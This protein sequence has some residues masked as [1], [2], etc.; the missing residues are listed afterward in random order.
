MPCMSRCNLACF[1]S[2]E[3]GQWRQFGLVGSG[4]GLQLGCFSSSRLIQCC[5]PNSTKHRTDQYCLAKYGSEPSRWWYVCLHGSFRLSKV[6][7]QR[8]LWAKWEHSTSG[9]EWPRDAALC[10]EQD[11]AE[12]SNFALRESYCRETDEF[13]TFC[14]LFHT[15]NRKWNR[16]CS[17]QMTTSRKF[18]A[19]SKVSTEDH[20]S[21]TWRDLWCW[22]RHGQSIFKRYLKRTRAPADIKLTSLCLRW[23]RRKSRLYKVPNQP[24]HRS[25]ATDINP[26]EPR[27]FSGEEQGSHHKNSILKKKAAE[28]FVGKKMLSP[29]ISPNQVSWEIFGV[30]FCTQHDC[31]ITSEHQHQPQ[32]KE[33]T[34]M[35]DTKTI[36][37]LVFDPRGQSRYRD[38]GNWTMC[39]A[40]KKTKRMVVIQNYILCKV[41]KC[42]PT[43][44][45]K[46]AR[47]EGQLHIN[48]TACCPDID[49]ELKI[50]LTQLWLRT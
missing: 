28:R 21:T 48:C 36:L 3:G 12:L 34:E 32:K 46:Q 25:G 40:M 20:G 8:F 45:P 31:K 49:W 30:P 18:P 5:E 4:C 33:S 19:A 47:R 38:P 39:A 24:E 22:I 43:C 44:A 11:R 41:C 35:D 29:G 2:P 9:S 17:T 6:R 13:E 7:P 37:C 15:R 50:F 23:S 42:E 26:I 16:K 27:N 1:P 10:G 14:S